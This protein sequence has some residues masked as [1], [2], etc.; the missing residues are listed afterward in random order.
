MCKVFLHYVLFSDYGSKKCIRQIS[1]SV[2]TDLFRW[3]KV[4]RSDSKVIFWVL[5]LQWMN[6]W[7]NALDR[8]ERFN[9]L[10]TCWVVSL[11]FTLFAS[12]SNSGDIITNIKLSRNVW[13]WHLVLMRW[14][15]LQIHTEIKQT[16]LKEIHRYITV[17][18]SGLSR[19]C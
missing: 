4:V 3:I 19:W 10:T 15:L 7:M 2:F 17:S 5:H 12:S 14:L 8:Q 9:F 11:S 6:E 18:S 1:D 16:P 13:V